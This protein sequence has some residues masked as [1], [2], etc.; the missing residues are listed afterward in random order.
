MFSSGTFRVVSLCVCVCVCVSELHS[1]VFI[2]VSSGIMWHE[3]RI[4][5]ILCPNHVSSSFIPINQ[6]S[7]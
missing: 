7:K 2:I 1:S 5:E 6:I 3:G 4:S